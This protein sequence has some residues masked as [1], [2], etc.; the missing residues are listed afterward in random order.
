MPFL[1]QSISTENNN[2]NCIF[3]F[4]FFIGCYIICVSFLIYTLI[5][6]LKYHLR[7]KRINQSSTTVLVKIHN[8]GEQDTMTIKSELDVFQPLI[9]QTQDLPVIYME[10]NPN[11]PPLDYKEHL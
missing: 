11:Q 5:R 6:L 9:I 4:Y 10:N 2:P 1:F 8:V 7:Q 3:F